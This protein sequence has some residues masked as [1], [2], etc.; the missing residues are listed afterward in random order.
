M[1]KYSSGLI[2]LDV[3][4]R[5]RVAQRNRYRDQYSRWVFPAVLALITLLIFI[6]AGTR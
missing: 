6:A 1:R 4:P 5:R 2:G 3:K